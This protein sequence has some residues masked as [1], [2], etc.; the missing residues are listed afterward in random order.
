MLWPCDDCGRSDDLPRWRPAAPVQ[1]G[2]GVAVTVPP[3]HKYGN[4]LFCGARAAFFHTPF[5]S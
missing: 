2:D 1:I 4:V 3:P 5:P